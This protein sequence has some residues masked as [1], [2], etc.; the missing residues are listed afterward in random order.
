MNGRFGNEMSEQLQRTLL[1]RRVAAAG[2]E[3]TF[4][5]AVVVSSVTGERHWVMQR[6]SDGPLGQVTGVSLWVPATRF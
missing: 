1:R 6:V 3:S 4:S 2:D 5:S